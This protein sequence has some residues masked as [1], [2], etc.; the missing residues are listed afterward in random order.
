MWSSRFVADGLPPIA[1]RYAVTAVNFAKSAHDSERMRSA[2]QPGL[3]GCIVGGRFG[4]YGDIKRK[5]RLKR[6]GPEKDKKQREVHRPPK[7]RK[8]QTS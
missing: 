6:S 2:T 4:K 7:K 3:G 1:C 5:Q 8:R